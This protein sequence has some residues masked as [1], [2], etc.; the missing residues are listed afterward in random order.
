MKKYIQYL[1]IT[2]MILTIMT[3]CHCSDDSY[4]EK[5]PDPS[6]I[7]EP[8]CEKIMTGVFQESKVYGPGGFGAIYI[9]SFAQALGFPNGGGR[10]EADSY[11]NPNG[12]WSEFFKALTAFRVLENTYNKLSDADKAENDVFVWISQI[13]IYERLSGVV[14][15]WGD[16]PFTEAGTLPLTGNIAASTPKFDTQESIYRTMLTDLKELNNKLATVQLSDATKTKL[17]VQDYVNGGDILQWRRYANSLR[18]R[19]GIRL[20]SQGGLQEEGK[21][22]VAEILGNETTYPIPTDNENMLALYCSSGPD[23]RWTEMG[24][25]DA[26]RAHGIASHAPLSH[27]VNSNDPRLEITYARASGTGLYTGLNPSVPYNTLTDELTAMK[28]HYSS[29]DSSSFRYTNE[30]IPSL[31]FSAAEIWFI[32]A[33]AYQRGIASGNAEAAFKKGIDLSVKMYYSINA[34]ATYKAPIPMPAQ[35]VIDDFA[36]ERWTAYPTKEEAIATQKWLH[37]GFLQEKEAWHELRRTGL[38]RLRFATDP[39]ARC[40]NVPSRLKYPDS[41]RQYNSENCP[42]VE[43]D[44]WETTLLW[45]KADWYEKITL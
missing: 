43:D 6:K 30:N 2:G 38:P 11:A 29:V 26:S 27:M 37:F 16:M 18:L 14:A 41:E 45:G 28:K 10:Y 35:S 17:S 5:Y 8:T 25:N 36:N 4:S 34:G 7:S 23:L 15:T 9:G 20:S 12:Q 22:A 24:Y 42:R 31:I 39:G 33:E 32:R 13:Y 3:F 21:A 1:S 19:L 40:P 44:N